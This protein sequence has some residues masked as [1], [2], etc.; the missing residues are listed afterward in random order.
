[1][2]QT[3]K[4]DLSGVLKRFSGAMIQPTLFLAVGGIVLAVSVL[5]KM[6]GMP[7]ALVALGTFV[8]TVLMNGVISNLPV[9][10]CVG[11]TVSLA[12]KKK[13]DA[14]VIAICSFL[15]F[16]Q[17]NHAWLASTGML[18]D[19]EP[20]ALWGTGQNMV[21]GVQV[22]DTGVFAGIVLACLNGW[23]I[24]KY[25]NVQFPDVVHIYG[26]TRFAYAL[27]LVAACLFGI[28][29]VHVWPVINAGI[30][31]LQGT[32][33]ASGSFGVFLYGF[34][35]RI[36][37]PV[38][39]HHL[40]YMPFLY[41]A[42]GGS[43]AIAGQVYEGAYPIFM[44]EMGNA[45]SLTAM[46]ESVRFMMLGL[47]KIFGTT[48]AVLAFI[49][50]AKPEYRKQVISMLVPAALVAALAGITEPF[51]FMYLFASPLLFVAHSVLDG[52]FQVILH[53]SG[54]RVML[55]G[56]IE[57]IPGFIVLP[58]SLTRW[59]LSIPIGILGIGTWFIVFRTLILK[60]DLK[61]PGREDYDALDGADAP[62]VAPK[63]K[64]VA[65]L[66]DV[67]DLIEG[68]GGS[69]NIVSVLNCMTRLRVDLKD[70]S[71]VDEGRINR[72]KNSGIVKGKNNVQI[73]IGMRVQ[74]A[75]DAIE[76]KLGRSSS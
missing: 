51:E 46:D 68:M 63:A 35:N 9:I 11:L 75:C 49:S 36:L 16:L 41:S 73:I 14:A 10:F 22:D 31:S 74:E 47:G 19:L 29:L 66:G 67:T 45:A 17:A 64:G 57:T 71:L 15:V 60:L 37:I 48:G 28:A 20:D 76:V 33:S 50:T 58:A 18:L 24:N 3:D 61:T 2:E 34:L 25:S 23:I 21:L 55:T 7:S 54:F 8:Y 62:A 32:M 72:F 40:I 12:K 38:G 65:A 4:I 1:M 56:L 43:V 53:L 44:A 13:A 42:V 59:Y 30:N 52:I 69:D 6:E 39:L 5:L 26:G 70:M 27:C